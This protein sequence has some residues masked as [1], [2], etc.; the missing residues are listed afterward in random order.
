M[1]FIPLYLLFIVFFKMARWAAYGTEKFRSGSRIFHKVFDQRYIDDDVGSFA[2]EASYC[3]I[4]GLIPF[5]IFLV[6]CILFFAAPQL[7][8]ILDLLQYL[9]AQFAASMEENIARI[10][11][12]RSTIWLFAGLGGAVWTASQGTAVLVRG[13]DKIFFQDRNIQS[14]FK[15]SLKACFFTVFLVFAMI[16]SLTLIVFANA[17]VFLVQDYIMEL[18]PVF[19]QVWR[20]SRYAIPFVVMSLSLSAFYR[21]APNR[22]ITKWTRIIPASF[23]VAAALLFLTAGYGYYILHIS[24]MGVTY[25]SLIGLIFLFLW[26]HLAVQIILAGGAVIMAW[27]DMRHRRL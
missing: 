13:M 14:W 8:T 17:V 19:W 1:K 6:N 21:Y 27:E 24:G 16:L 5:M 3:F 22:Y 4:L 10:I 11:A 7:D 18:P 23:L 12:G 15:V 2:S 26:I 9:P 25:G 20:P